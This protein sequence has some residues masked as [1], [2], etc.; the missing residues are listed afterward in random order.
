MDKISIRAKGFLE[1]PQYLKA[2][3]LEDFEVEL[4]SS[5]KILTVFH[6]LNSDTIELIFS[7]ALAIFSR[8]R[9]ENELWKINFREFENFLRDENH[10]PAFEESSELLEEKLIKIKISLI[11]CLIKKR[12]KAD[13]AKLE[14]G[15]SHWGNLNLTSRNIWAKDFLSVLGWELIFCNEDS[16][17]VTKAPPGLA[18]ESLEFL[19]QKIFRQGVQGIPMKVV[20]V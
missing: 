1:S 17:T 12:M 18:N 6:K 5:D 8:N 16:L 10:L 11:A 20:A 15:I 13:F 9:T 19:F 4:D 7:E 3:L 14:E 2:D